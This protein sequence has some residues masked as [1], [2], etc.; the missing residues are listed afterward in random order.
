MVVVL[1]R[2]ASL[3][4]SK[5]VAGLIVTP[6]FF[7]QFKDRHIRLNDTGLSRG[8]SVVSCLSICVDPAVNCQLIEATSP[9]SPETAGIDSRVQEKH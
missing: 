5:N 4:P 9:P 6:C 8:V 1:Q 3:P 7:Q 2:L